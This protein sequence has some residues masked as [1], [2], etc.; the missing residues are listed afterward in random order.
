MRWI[1]V[2]MVL[3]RSEAA[4]APWIQEEDAL[5]VRISVADEIVEGLRGTRSDVYAEYGITSRTTLSF[6]AERIRYGDASDFNSD[7][8]RATVRRS[9]INIG[10][11]TASA[12]LGALQ[13]AA[14]GG[15]N[16]CDTLGIE[17]R[18]GLSWSG[19]WRNRQ[20]FAFSEVAT[21]NY[22]KCR[23]DRLELGFGQQATE[24]LWNIIQVWLERGSPNAQSY[25][26][27]SEVLWRGEYADFSIGYRQEIGGVFQEESVFLAVARQF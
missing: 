4:A 25:K 1:S 17:L 24:R 27:Q 6:K 15:R 11:F 18:S 26:V 22:K 7:G 5:Y 9:L 12:E 3:S 2:F 8:W 10:A 16:G 23:R 14:I 21:R 13:G 19:T 20:T